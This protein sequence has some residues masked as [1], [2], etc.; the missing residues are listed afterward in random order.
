MNSA[1]NTKYS[2][3]R[4]YIISTFICFQCKLSTFDPHWSSLRFIANRTCRFWF[5]LPDARTTQEDDR[6]TGRLCIEH[7]VSVDEANGAA[8]PLSSRALALCTE[9]QLHAGHSLDLVALRLYSPI[10]PVWIWMDWF[11]GILF[12]HSVHHFSMLYILCNLFWILQVRVYSY[13]VMKITA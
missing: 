11:F 6:S 4:W 10:S 3:L 12:L 9:L 8:S 2:T 13:V 5:V 7:V 1:I